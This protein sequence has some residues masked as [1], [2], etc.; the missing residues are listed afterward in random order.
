VD[1]SRQATP[2][3]QTIPLLEATVAPDGI[4]LPAT[5]AA[6]EMLDDDNRSEAMQKFVDAGDQVGVV[7]KKLNELFSQQ[8]RINMRQQ[9]EFYSR[10]VLLPAINELGEDDRVRDQLE[11]ELASLWEIIA[12]LEPAS[13]GLKLSR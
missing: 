7:R 1:T 5:P 11:V 9:L 4:T 3:W 6:D 8:G 13:G 2:D 10:E 12:E